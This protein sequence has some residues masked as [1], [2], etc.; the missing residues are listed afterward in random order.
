MTL[1]QSIRFARA[2]DGA[3]VAVASVGSGPPLVRAAH[4]LSHVEYDPESPVWRPWLEALSQDHTYTR[5]D[6]RG[7]GLSDREVTDFTLDAWVDDLEA[8]TETIAREPFPLIGMSQGGAVAIAYILRNPGRV[9]RLILVGAYA[10]GGLRR[11]DNPAFRRTFTHRFIPEGSSEQIRWWSDLERITASPEVAARTLEAFQRIDVTDLAR[12]IDVP[13]LVLHSRGDVC[14]PFEE[15][16]LLASLIPSARFVPV[17]S[18][19]HVLLPSEPAWRPF[20]DEVRAFLAADRGGTPLACD[21]ALTPAEA[22]VLD[23]VCD[24]LDNRAI[25]AR[26]GKS[27]KT[28]RNQVTSVLSKLGV[29]SR[30]EAIVVGREARRG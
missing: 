20:F 27:P 24:G 26:L 11:K 18:N 14:V 19:N 1:R 25:A 21:A 16:R 12:Q 22:D 23:L 29:H 28:V 6:Q 15:G 2:R 13:T 17:E 30:T 9:S 8:V 10:R 7:C 4:W 3:R 5:Y